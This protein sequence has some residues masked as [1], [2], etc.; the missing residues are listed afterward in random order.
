MAESVLLSDLVAF[1]SARKAR[2]TA[3]AVKLK[4][5][6]E[7][8]AHD[9]GR[10]LNPK[11]A[12]HSVASQVAVLGLATDVDSPWVTEHIGLLHI[13]I[14]IE[15]HADRW[16]TYVMAGMSKVNEYT[17]PLEECEGAYTLAG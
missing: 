16:R 6:T 17:L 12:R 1:Q 14:S 7:Y 8:L 2:S 5:S 10:Q 3:Y 15:D 4:H 9:F 11:R 13:T